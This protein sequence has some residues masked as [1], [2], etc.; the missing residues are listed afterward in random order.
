MKK[1]GRIL[2]LVLAVCLI[3]AC[4][5][6]NVMAESEP[7]TN[8]KVEVTIDKTKDLKPG[9]TITVSLNIENTYHI[10]SM[11]YT[12]AYDDDVFEVDMTE[13]AYRD[14]D[15]YTEITDQGTPGNKKFAGYLTTLTYT[16]AWDLDNNKLLGAGFKGEL[17]Y[18]WFGANYIPE[19]KDEPGK[20]IGKFYF[21]VK[22]DAAGGTYM[23]NVTGNTSN[24]GQVQYPMVT[25]PVAVT[26]GSGASDPVDPS[27]DN[28][29]V[30]PG[31]TSGVD[32]VAGDREGKKYDNAYAVTASISNSNSNAA[33]ITAAGVLFIPEAVLGSE[34]LTLSTTSAAKAEA[35]AAVLGNGTLTLKAAIKDIPAALANRDIKM[36]TRAYGVTS[37]DPI[38]GAQNT[39]TINFT[40]TAE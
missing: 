18:K 8:R 26:V 29:T 4:F 35:P 14:L 11:G 23:I 12:V 5:T 25:T 9:D 31:S 37:G 10:V 38:Y 28:I 2:S 15:W 3:S 19:T 32:I 13:D 16:P 33:A 6:V 39:T 21:K 17:N 7:K 24:T 40:K 34:T 1:I 20:L 22:D 36:V 30:T 27:T